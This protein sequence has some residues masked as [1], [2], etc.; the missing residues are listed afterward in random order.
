MLKEVS[1]EEVFGKEQ[2]NELEVSLAEFD[3]MVKQKKLLDELL[4]SEAFQV[5]IVEGYLEDD[6]ER[7]TGLLKN[8]SVNS[9]VVQER[10]IIV[11]KIV[12]KG[13]LENWLET[14]V[15]NTNGIDNPEHRI[16][17]LKQLAEVEAEQEE[18]NE[19]V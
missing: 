4:A 10:Q 2:P 7:L 9:K 15:K 6:Y 11:D 17:L 16:Q 19:E 12:S 14:L 18:L 8:T 5:I 3:K 1:G 13:Y